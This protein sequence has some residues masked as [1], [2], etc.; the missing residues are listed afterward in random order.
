MRHRGA[1]FAAFGIFGVMYLKF[2]LDEEGNRIYTLKATDPQGRQTQSAHPARFSPEDKNSKYR[3]IIKKLFNML[4]WEWRRKWR[5][6][7][8]NRRPP[9][10][11]SYQQ[12]TKGYTRVSFALFIVGW[13]VIGFVIWRK[14]EKLKKD[15][16]QE[17]VLLSEIPQKGFMELSDEGKEDIDFEDIDR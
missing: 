11:L 16:P 17:K 9:S 15:N 14:V 2:Y 5:Q 4:I 8:R 6:Y 1:A 7:I 13:H 3:I 12:L 10:R